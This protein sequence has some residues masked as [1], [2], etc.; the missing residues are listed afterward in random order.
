MKKIVCLGDS[1]TYGY[2]V[3]RSKVWTKLAED[4]LHIEIINEG[5]CGDTSGRHGQQVS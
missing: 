3:S 4:K 2:G 5:I 1:L